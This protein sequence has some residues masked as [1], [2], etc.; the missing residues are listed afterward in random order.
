MLSKMLNG[1]SFNYMAMNI[2]KLV[3]ESI[4]YCLVALRIRSIP[5]RP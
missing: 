3:N 4:L 5:N 1:F 2:I